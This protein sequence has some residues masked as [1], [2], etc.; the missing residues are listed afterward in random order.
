MNT[1]VR[2][3]VFA[4]DWGRHP[5]SC[6]HLIGRLLP[7]YPTLWVNTI[8]TRLPKFTMED[9][10]KVVVKVRQWSGAG[11]A[12]AV[13]LPEHLE[14]VNPKMWPGFRAT[15]Q[16]RINARLMSRAVNGALGAR[17]V[18]EKRV[19]VSTL[20]I[21]ADLVGRIDADAWIYYCVDDFS[22]WPGL[23]GE[24]I[25]RME[26]DL[27]AKVDAIVA[28]SDTLVARMAEMGGQTRLITHG[29]DLGHW[30]K[31]AES[32]EDE[33]CAEWWPASGPVSLF[34]GVI[35]TFEISY[36]T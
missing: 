23:D 25:D 9:L 24:V 15:W 10:A 3:V 21:T 34:W 22:V 32:V 28:V 13:A 6:Q 14:T 33:A 30:R 29:I 1:P 11:A 12:E 7:R 5:S 18:G 27:V 16:R 8:G 4:D 36:F 2:L 20:P 31:P 35:D 26:R 17:D 19:V